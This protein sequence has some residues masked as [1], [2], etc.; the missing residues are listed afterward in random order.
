MIEQYDSIAVDSDLTQGALYKVDHIVK[1]TINDRT[2]SVMTAEDDGKRIRLIHDPN[3]VTVVQ[4]LQD[5]HVV[6]GE[7]VASNCVTEVDVNER[8]NSEY[9]FPEAWGLMSDEKRA[10]WF[11]K[12]RAWW[13]LNLQY[14]NGM[15]QQ[16][17]D[18]DGVSLK[19]G[20]R[21]AETNDYKL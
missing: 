18:F 20:W 21:D 8:N 10:E 6:D 9:N 13:Q 4:I 1:T 11:L 15:W 12:R 3:G 2:I 7:I 16:W 5:R 19:E 14:D 17:D